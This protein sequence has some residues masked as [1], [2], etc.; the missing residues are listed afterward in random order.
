[1]E[2]SRLPYDG[3][4]GTFVARFM[5]FYNRRLRR[6]AEKRREKGIF[7]RE[8][9]HHR[10]LLAENFSPNNRVLRLL[11]KGLCV[12]IKAEITTALARSRH[13]LTQ[14]E[15]PAQVAKAELARSS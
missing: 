3:P 14:K 6:V 15:T 8:N 2:W 7:A 4:I 12:W 13:H 1:V 10:H 11:V 5:A 9:L